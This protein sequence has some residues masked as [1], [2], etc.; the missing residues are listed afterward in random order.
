M[1]ITPQNISITSFPG[2]DRSIS[3]KRISEYDITSPIYRNRRIGDFLKEL[4]LIEGRNTGYPTVLN[5]LRDN[6]SSYP[7]FEMDEGRNYLTVKLSI[8]PYF[9][10]NMIISPKNWSTVKE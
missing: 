3:D 8:H 7:E 10:P 5:A 2:F 9:L 4:H 1:R 6:G